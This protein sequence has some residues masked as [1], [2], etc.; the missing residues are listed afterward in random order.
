MASGGHGLHFRSKSVRKIF[1]CEQRF[2]R[3]RTVFLQCSSRNALTIIR[4]F[5]KCPS[6][7]RICAV[8]LEPRANEHNILS[9]QFP[10]L[11]DV[12]RCVRLHPVACC[13][14]LLGVIAQSSKTVK[15]F[16][17][18]LPPF[19]FLFRDRRSLAQQPAGQ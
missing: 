9:Q 5:Q 4:R 11:L 3:I 15:L 10:I 7:Q 19:L 14:V 18:Q 2:C 6:I 8:C 1:V 17:R 12:K 13:C 16:S